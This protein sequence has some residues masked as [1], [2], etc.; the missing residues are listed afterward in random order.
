ME[1]TAEDLIQSPVSKESLHHQKIAASITEATGHQTSTQ[2][3]VPADH[4]SLH[5][6]QGSNVLD[7]PGHEREIKQEGLGER[8][9]DLSDRLIYDRPGTEASR[10]FLTRLKDR[11]LKKNPGKD[12]K[13]A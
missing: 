12:L 5:P 6:A 4:P 13:A 2:Q 8:I 9:A 11:L 10:S 1:K 7:F 3:V